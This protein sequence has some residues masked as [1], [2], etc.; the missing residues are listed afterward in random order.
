[1]RET[2][3]L[4]KPKKEKSVIREDEGLPIGPRHK[5]TYKFVYV[6]FPKAWT[7]D[8][9]HGFLPNL[10]KIKARPGLNGVKKDGSMALT[11]ARVSEMGGT[12]VDPKDERLGDFQD[13]VCYYPIR[14]STDKYYVDWNQSA[15]VLPS[16]EIIWNNSEQQETWKDFLLHVRD[17]GIIAPLLRE[18]YVGIVEREKNK[19]N[20]LIGRVDRNPHLATRLK[21]CEERIEGM[22]KFWKEHNEKLARAKKPSTPKKRTAKVTT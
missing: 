2:L 12:A 15:V 21:R 18:V 16:D 3:H 4:T 20:S 17:S 19:L 22:Q 6:H 5:R 13:Y 14:G 9:K 8:T 1:M 11:L 10:K 7:F